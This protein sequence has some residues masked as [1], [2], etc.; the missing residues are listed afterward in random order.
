ME[1]IDKNLKSN[2]DLLKAIL[3][4][5][6]V[7]WNNFTF[8]RTDTLSEIEQFLKNNYKLNVKKHRPL[9][10]KNPVHQIYQF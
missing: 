5:I 8:N 2:Q 7:P 6:T 9:Q 4:D 10:E 3:D 1:S